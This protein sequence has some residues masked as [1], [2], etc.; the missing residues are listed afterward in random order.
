[1]SS[2]GDIDTVL[3]TR[4]RYSPKIVSTN[5]LDVGSV[6]YLLKRRFACLGEEG[7]V[8]AAR[9]H[10]LIFLSAVFNVH[11][12]RNPVFLEMYLCATIMNLGLVE[13]QHQRLHL[14]WPLHAPNGGV[15]DEMRDGIT[16][17]CIEYFGNIKTC[18]ETME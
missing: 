18:I 8:Q 11:I 12:E 17:R 6:F 14:V 4:R 5:L 10:T 1:M 9:K 15:L 7:C 13:I 16:Q 2:E 3:G